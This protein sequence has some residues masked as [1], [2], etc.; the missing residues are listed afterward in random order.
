MI[1]IPIPSWRRSLDT[2]SRTFAGAMVSVDVDRP[3]LGLLAEVK[4]QPLAGITADRSGIVVQVARGVEHLD[5]T[6]PDAEEL[7]FEETNEGA[8]H[9]VQVDS[10][11][12]TRTYIRFRS[13]L[14]EALLDPNVE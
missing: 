1:T 8:L 14:L 2:M 3:D 11:D 10:R 9:S 6:I 7:R 12:G 5:H 13:P 4:S